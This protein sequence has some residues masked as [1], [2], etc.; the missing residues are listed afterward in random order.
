[1]PVGV[2]VPWPLETPPTGWLK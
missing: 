2:P 1:M